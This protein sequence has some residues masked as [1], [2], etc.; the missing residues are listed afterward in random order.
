M[1][2]QVSDDDL[3]DFI[4]DDTACHSSKS[5][6]T[7]SNTAC[8]IPDK[9]QNR[10]SQL[11]SLL[12]SINVQP[13]Q[14]EPNESFGLADKEIT[15]LALCGKLEKGVVTVNDFQHSELIPLFRAWTNMKADQNYNSVT[16]QYKNV[17]RVLQHSEAQ[18]PAQTEVISLLINTIQISNAQLKENKQMQK[19]CK[20]DLLLR[21]L[22]LAAV[23]LE[24]HVRCENLEV[25]RQAQQLTEECASMLRELDVTERYIK[26]R[27]QRHKYTLRS[28]YEHD[29]QANEHVMEARKCR[30]ELQ[31][32]SQNL[33]SL[34]IE[35]SQN[36][37]VQKAMSRTQPTQE[38]DGSS[39][40]TLGGLILQETLRQ[41]LHQEHQ[42]RGTN[43]FQSHSS[44]S[45]NL[46][47]T[48][49]IIKLV[50]D[51][52]RD[53]QFCYERMLDGQRTAQQSRIKSMNAVKTCMALLQNLVC[54][55]PTMYTY[56]EHAAVAAA[57]YWRSSTQGCLH[58]KDMETSMAVRLFWILHAH[59][60]VQLPDLDNK[61]SYL[62]RDD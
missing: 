15:S 55:T 34:I 9:R 25:V 8:R 23:I 49:E 28:T 56:I 11:R 36:E 22:G 18:R 59:D 21:R 13:L 39:L 29:V 58:L 12:T 7:A 10:E 33:E 24:H 62:T 53:A 14:P 30:Q 3:S 45:S 60:D 46:Y 61:N 38:T 35:S 40:M 5:A 42:R 6:F 37:A 50:T 32:A 41:D 57:E 31:K 48:G 51:L 47:Q 2:T 17:I 16:D 43:D 26:K 27:I 20:I 4:N 54:E 44:A 19:A 1:S 52:S